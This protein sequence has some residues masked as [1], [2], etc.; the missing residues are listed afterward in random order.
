VSVRLHQCPRC[1]SYVVNRNRQTGVLERCL[2]SLFGIRPY[3]CVE[4]GCR[5]WD[6]LLGTN[7][8]AAEDPA[9][10]SRGRGK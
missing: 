5:F 9:P 4:C 1:A 10:R 3:L 7:R 2:L 8:G 6:R